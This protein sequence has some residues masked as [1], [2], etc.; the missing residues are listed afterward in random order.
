MEFVA[1]AMGRWEGG[2]C[3]R[4]AKPDGSQKV[5]YRSERRA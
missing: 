1:A 2:R 5:A 3:G 4:R